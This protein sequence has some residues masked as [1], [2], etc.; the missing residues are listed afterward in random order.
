MFQEGE[1]ALRH[2]V[3]IELRERRYPIWIGEGLLDDVGALLSN[4]GVGRKGLVVTDE[5]VAPLYAERVL[6]SLEAAGLSVAP[7][8]VPPGESTKSLQFA[9]MLYDRAVEA[10]L[11]RKSFIAALGGGVVGDLA[12]FVAATYMRGIDFVQLPTTL[13]AQ[14]DASVGGKVAVNHSSTKNL[15]GAFHQPRLVVCDIGTLSTL[16]PTEMLSGLAEVIKHG[17]IADA[18]LFR[19]IEVH[20]KASLA[21]ELPAL[22]HF[23][24]RSCEI[25]GSVVAEDERETS[26]RATLNFGHTIGHGLESAAGYGTLT[27]GEAV[28]IGMVSASMVSERLGMLSSAQVTRI[29][30]LLESAGYRLWLPG[31]DENALF[32]AVLHDKKVVAGKI[33][34]ALLADIGR[35]VVVQNVPQELLKEVVAVQK[36]IAGAA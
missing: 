22:V 21:A 12:G 35:G 23:V 18:E 32:A 13:L 7:A 30:R 34:M 17:L 16:P 9:S 14:V 2:T 4:A 6:R 15:I 1:G 28:A 29:C 8:V 24:T 20:P 33:T 19:F 10:G 26:L 31:V 25:K 5:A 3:W 11:D 36:A 27:H